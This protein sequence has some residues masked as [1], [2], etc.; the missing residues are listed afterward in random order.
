M[1]VIRTQL[2]LVSTWNNI[3]SRI[4]TSS[5]SWVGTSRSF[6]KPSMVLPEAASEAEEDEAVKEADKI[7]G[8]L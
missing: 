2:W 4:K 5:G 1:N 3:M 7:G 8:R 6:P